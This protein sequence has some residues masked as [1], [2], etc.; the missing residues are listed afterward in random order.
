MPDFDSHLVRLVYFC[1]LA[2]VRI[3]RR[4]D[5]TLY[6]YPWFRL[7]KAWPFCPAQGYTS[8]LCVCQPSIDSR[9]RRFVA[10]ELL[11]LHL[12]MKTTWPAAPSDGGQ[13][14]E[15]RRGQGA[16]WSRGRVSCHLSTSPGRLCLQM[17]V[18]NPTSSPCPDSSR[19]QGSPARATAS[20]ADVTQNL[21]S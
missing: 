21:E 20:P 6:L 11:G 2:V 16:A 19:M 1:F 5:P 18:C 9:V 7:W 12:Q 15:V 4:R 3:S 13:M 14:G 10:V 8:V 17:I